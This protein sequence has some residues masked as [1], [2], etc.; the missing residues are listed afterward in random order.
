MGEQEGT[1]NVEPLDIVPFTTSEQPKRE[2]VDIVDPDMVD[3][4][5]KPFEKELTNTN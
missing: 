2:S 5:P 3:T 1:G 4:N